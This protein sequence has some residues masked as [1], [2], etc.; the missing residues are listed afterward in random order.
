MAKVSG[1]DLEKKIKETKKPITLREW[2]ELNKSTIQKAL[3]KG[4]TSE[5]MIRI[6]FGAIRNNPNLLTCTRISFISAI[7]SSIQLGLEPNTVLGQAYLIPYYNSKLKCR[8][9]QFQLG[10][11]GLLDLA[12]RTGQFLEIY[13]QEVYEGDQFAF[14]LGTEKFIRHIPTDSPVK[15]KNDKPII[16]YVYA[17]YKKIKGGTHFVVWPTEKLERHKE[18]YVKAFQ[19]GEKEKKVDRFSAWIQSPIPMYK[20]T[21][22]KDLL[23]YA[24]ISVEFRRKLEVDETV[25][26]EIR[27]DM[28]EVKPVY[29]YD[30]TEEVEEK[31]EKKLE[32]KKKEE[33]VE[34]RCKAILKSG[35]KCSYSA[36][37]GSDYCGMHKKL[38]TKKQ[39]KRYHALVKEAGV[40]PQKAD[41]RIKEKYQVEHKKDLTMAQIDEIF[42]GL[43][44]KIKEMKKEEKSE[45]TIVKPT[46]SELKIMSVKRKGAG[47]KK[48]EFDKY[49]L[50]NYKAKTP[51]QLTKKQYDEIIEFLDKKI[52]EG[53]EIKEDIEK[54]EQEKLI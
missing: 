6:L 10:Y 13:A 27:P 38:V 25:K 26:R 43:E 15:D 54:I 1:K 3:P 50:D 19:K 46:T 12:Y 21:V 36:K 20:K 41:D 28:I 53:I 49:L 31:L 35:E 34:R 39:L 7:M 29:E 52:E 23:K 32:E 42:K 44:K 33:K 30:A 9:V 48:E 17:I 11:K 8:E 14:E 40:D 5:R 45:I 24:D 4:F 47:Y 18:K 22:V 16:T 2:I 37:P 51:M